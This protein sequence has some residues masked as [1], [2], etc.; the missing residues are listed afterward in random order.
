MERVEGRVFFADHCSHEELKEK[1]KNDPLVSQMD[2][3]P[4]DFVISDGD[5]ERGCKREAPYDV[6]IASHVIE[7]VPNL[8]GWLVSVRNLLC[9]GGVLCL[10]VPDKRFT[11]DYL[12]RLTTVKDVDEAQ[13]ENRMRPSL[14]T[15]CD[16]Y[17]NVIGIGPGTLWEAKPDLNANP[18]GWP[19]HVVQEKIKAHLRGEYVDVHCWVFTPWQFLS[20]IGHIVSRY[21][22]GFDLRYF[23]TTQPNEE[24]FHVQLEKVKSTGTKWSEL[25][26]YHRKYAARPTFS[27]AN[28]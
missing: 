1:Y 10:A 5:L 15:V 11:F 24:E 19:S 2:L 25:A 16:S 18:V 27:L 9:D 4:V 13:A 28:D 14:D 8:V 20:L 7:H 22:V 26:E 12:R 17:R 23:R 6:I 21:D 3:A